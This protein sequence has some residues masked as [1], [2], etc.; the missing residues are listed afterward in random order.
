[1]VDGNLI[2]TDE[3]ESKIVDFGALNYDALKMAIILNLEESQIFSLL[4]NKESDFYKLYE[5]GKILA[6]FAIDK[7]IFEM[8][9]SGDLKAISIFENKKLL[10]NA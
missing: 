3:I 5:K 9:K 4:N 8:A 7:K 2:I 6:E 1:M 10:N